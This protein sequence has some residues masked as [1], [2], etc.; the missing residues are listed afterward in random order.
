MK[1]T[2][3]INETNKATVATETII[4]CERRIEYIIDI[5]K[6]CDVEKSIR[7]NPDAVAVIK[8]MYRL[9]DRIY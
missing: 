7:D 8:E 6:G 9:V 4:D 5:L 3:A 2:T 1:T